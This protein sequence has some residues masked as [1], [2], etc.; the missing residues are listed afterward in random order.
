MIDRILDLLRE[1]YGAPSV[2]RRL[3]PLDELV[4]T[5]LSQNTS[6]TNCERAYASL[7]RRYP[8]WEDVRDADTADV[9]EVLR[10]GG[11]AAQKAPRIQAV[12]RELSDGGPPA[13]R[14]VPAARPVPVRPVGRPLRLTPVTSPPRRGSYG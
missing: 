4:L 2:H 1:R 10:P 12:L 3:P 7:R 5:I 14:R 13:L 9:E 6:D 11:L 8:R